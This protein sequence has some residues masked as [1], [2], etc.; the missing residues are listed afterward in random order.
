M[1]LDGAALQPEPVDSESGWK[2]EPIEKDQG[3]SPRYAD[4]FGDEDNA[5]VKYKTMEWW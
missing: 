2:E 3:G 1:V 4:A 5:E